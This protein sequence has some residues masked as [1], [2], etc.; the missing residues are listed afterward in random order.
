MN[1]YIKV[2]SKQNIAI[3]SI[4]LDGEEIDQVTFQEKPQ[5]DVQA[6]FLVATAENTLR[7]YTCEYELLKK[8]KIRTAIG[9]IVIIRITSFGKALVA[10]PANVSGMCQ[11]ISELEKYQLDK[12]LIDGAFSR[13]VFAR[14][15]QAT[16][17]VVGANYARDISSVVKNAKAITEKFNLETI[18]NKDLLDQKRI[19]FID[20]NQNVIEQDYS[21]IIGNLKRFF[22]SDFSRIKAVYFPKAITNQ[23]VKK[24]VESRKLCK[25]DLI[26]DSAVNIQLDE[27]NLENLFKLPNQIFVINKV[28]LALV[29]YNPYSPRGYSFDDDMFKEEL[30]KVLGFN[31]I[32]VLKDG[33]DE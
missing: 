27:L 7:N 8:T 24:L 15:A 9:Q 5:I 3:T 16:I 26:L 21:T 33:Y 23:F 13:N 25:F 17:L 29:C 31:V 32:N 22:D 30:E 18:A 28:N 19:C 6:G 10:G 2:L 14:L 1:A 12:I 4:G 11:V 20:G